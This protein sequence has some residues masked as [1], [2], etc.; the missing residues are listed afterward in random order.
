MTCRDL[1][2]AI[3]DFVAGDMPPDASA[4]VRAHLEGCRECCRYVDGYRR[5]IAAVKAVRD[6]EPPANRVRKFVDAALAAVG[7]KH[8]GDH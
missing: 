8:R 3:D 7:A 6:D 4:S 1:V 2:D 5:T